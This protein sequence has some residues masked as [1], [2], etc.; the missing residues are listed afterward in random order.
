MKLNAGPEDPV[1]SRLAPPNLAREPDRPTGPPP[2]QLD[3]HFVADHDRD[4]KAHPQAVPGAIE[5]VAHQVS[6]QAQRPYADPNHDP[7]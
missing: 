3:H 1:G 2:G 7:S 5:Q 4:L 6:C